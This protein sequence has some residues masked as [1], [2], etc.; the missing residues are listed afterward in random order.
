MGKTRRIPGHMLAHFPHSGL[1]AFRFHL[2]ACM[3]KNHF[4]DFLHRRARQ[5][6]PGFQIMADLPEDP[7]V[8]PGRSSDHHAGAAGLLQHP[9]S[10]FRTVHIAIADHGDGYRLANLT[11]DLPVGFSGIILFS[12]PPV[13]GDGGNTA[14]L[15]NFR[16][17]HCIDMFLVKTFPDLYRH[18]FL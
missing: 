3:A 2:E 5:L 13:N 16:D 9:H 8:S 14:V 12:C 17:L 11:D 18:R 10:R 15:Q 6:L 7:R 4:P 1:H